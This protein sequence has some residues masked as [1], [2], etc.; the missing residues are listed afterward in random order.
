MNDAA[1]KNKELLIRHG[2]SVIEIELRAI[3]DLL[4][5]LDDSFARACQAILDCDGKTIVIGLGKSGHI[6]SKIAATL[7]STG[8]PAF[9]VHASEASHGDLGMISEKDVVMVIS[10]SGETDEITI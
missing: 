8:T 1:N 6:G 5:R 7:A 10:N 3:N 4:E 9:F 2:R